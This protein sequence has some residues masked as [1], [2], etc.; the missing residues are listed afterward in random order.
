MCASG[1]ASNSLITC[2][3][4]GRK[5]L[6]YH[7]AASAWES[8]ERLVRKTEEDHENLVVYKCY[9]H[10]MQVGAEDD[11][12]PDDAIEFE[13]RQ[14]GHVDFWAT[15]GRGLHSCWRPRNCRG[16][17]QCHLHWSIFQEQLNYSQRGVI[18]YFLYHP[19]WCGRRS[20]HCG[21]HLQHLWRLTPGCCSWCTSPN[22]RAPEK[23]D[24][25][26]YFWFLPVLTQKKKHVNKSE[27]I[28]C[29]RVEQEQLIQLWKVTKLSLFTCDKT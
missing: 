14:P 10:R 11:V 19:L 28:N 23:A 26:S 25:W 17:T 1:E 20:V 12:F 22:H 3:A 5:G 9:Y 13:R 2:E 15:G 24:W 18:W 8:A 21:H 6:M 29:G 27:C 16:T 4:K 7:W